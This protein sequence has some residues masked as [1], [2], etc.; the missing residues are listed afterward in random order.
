MSYVNCIYIEQDRS[1]MVDWLVTHSFYREDELES[2]PFED[3]KGIY[4]AE[5][6]Y[7]EADE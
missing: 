4:E 6:G 3:I 7:V 5:T 2:M 1:E